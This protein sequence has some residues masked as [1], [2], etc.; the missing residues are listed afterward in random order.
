MDILLRVLDNFKGALFDFLWL[1]PVILISLTFHE[2]SHGLVAYLLGD[3]TAKNSGRLTLNPIKHLDPLGAIFLMIFR[4]GW[5]KPVPVN[6]MYFKKRKRDMS[7]VALAGPLSNIL[8]SFVSLLIYKILAYLI[9]MP[10]YATSFLVGMVFI[11]AGL[12]IFNLIPM[13]PLDGSKIFI[14]ILP[15]RAYYTIL[16]NEK[17]GQ[18]L[19]LLLLFTGILTMPLNFLSSALVNLLDS[20]TSLMLGGVFFVLSK[21]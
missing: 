14:S 13:S 18:I 4:F 17:Y 5:A 10:D 21:I 2:Y 19:I 1:A 6:P 9:D 11:N 7:L 15:D 12:A 8:L 3:P 20:I 16:Q